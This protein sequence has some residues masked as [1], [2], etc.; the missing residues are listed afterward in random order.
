MFPTLEHI[1]E[2]PAL[3]LHL[4]PEGLVRTAKQILRKPQSPTCKTGFWL[5]GI[6]SWFTLHER[7]GRT[8]QH[9][10][11][12]SLCNCVL[13]LPLL[14]KKIGQGIR[15]QSGKEDENTRGFASQIADMEHTSTRRPCCQ[16][17]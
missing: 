9:H 11:H 17:T 13:E 3:Q 2:S 15:G 4:L 7:P 1:P 8:T 6:L 12:M 14:P 5:H 16:A 10:P